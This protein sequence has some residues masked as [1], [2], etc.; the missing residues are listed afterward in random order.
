MCGIIGYVG[1]RQALPI[2]LEGLTRMEYR[3]YDSGVVAVV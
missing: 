3:G 1:K 2:V